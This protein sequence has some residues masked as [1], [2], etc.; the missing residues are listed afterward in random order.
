MEYI[1][2][3]QGYGSVAAALI[4]NNFNPSV[5][6][7][8]IDPRT[9]LSYVNM[10]VNGKEQAV[11]QHLATATLLRDQWKEIDRVVQR[12][13]RNR[14]RVVADLRA[15][16][17]TRALP[18]AMGKTVLLSQTMG[19]I[20]P[21]RVSMDPIAESDADRPEFG[22]VGLPIPV[23]HKDFFFTARQIAV[24]A[25]QGIPLDTT[26][27]EEATVKCVEEADAMALGTSTGMVYAGYT[28]YGLKSHPNRITKALTAPTAAGWT[29]DVFLTE[30]LEMVQSLINIKYYGPYR[31]YLSPGWTIYLGSDYSAAVPG[32]TLGERVRKVVDSVETVDQ[33]TGFEAL[34][35]QRTRSVIE[36]VEGMDFRAVQWETH[37]GMRINFKILGIVV[38]R[39]RADHKGNTGIVHGS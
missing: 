14:I 39:V 36:L 31:L 37:G 19:D 22:E 10:V 23:I 3:G 29:P 24:A 5:M 8:F 6:R 12:V 18:N 21:A 16:R 13:P 11:M 33:L 4:A 38:P 28:V 2:Q 20:T 17:L 32:V 27:V 35:Y 15:D 1:H 30:V 34:L 25:Q 7:P 26:E 9:N